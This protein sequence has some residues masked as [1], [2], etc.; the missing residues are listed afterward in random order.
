MNLKYLEDFFIKFLNPFVSLANYFLRFGLGI[1]FIIHGLSKF[2]LPP[3]SLMNYF[4]FGPFLSSSVAISEVLAGSF[5]ILGG[6][7][8]NYL[9]SL[10]TRLS[11][12]VIIVIMICAFYFAHK[13]WFI[14]T[15]LFTSEQIFLLLIG[16]YFL[17]NGNKKSH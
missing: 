6:F 10:I 9:G 12:C 5:L 2:P 17:I 15:K 14:N 8:K 11:S 4:K 7:I 13:D 3:E 16:T 1:A